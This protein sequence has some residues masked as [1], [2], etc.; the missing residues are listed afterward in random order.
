[1]KPLDSPHP[2][3]M[4]KL[5]SRP[6]STAY[7]SVFF[8]DV[9]NSQHFAVVSENKKPTSDKI[10][11]WIFRQEIYLPS[12]AVG[13]G[14]VVPVHPRKVLTRAKF[15]RLIQSSYKTSVFSVN[16]H[17]DA[18]IIKRSDNLGCSVRRAIIDDQ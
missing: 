17:P 15:D 1:M 6:R 9:A 16:N 13:K 10:D 5:K 4:R 12:H 7:I 11:V 14:D 2:G 18:R 3:W 8:N